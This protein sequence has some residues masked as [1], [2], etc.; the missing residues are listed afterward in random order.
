MSGRIPV[1]W[2]LNGNVN[3]QEFTLSGEGSA[4]LITGTTELRLEAAPTLPNGFEPALSH[5][6]CNFALAGYT[7]VPHVA[8]SLRDVVASELF[9]RPRRQVEITDM[10]G[11]QIV[12]LEA[13]TTMT[14]SD[15]VISVTNYMTGFSHLPAPVLNASGAETLVPGTPGTATGTAQ[16]QVEL[17]NGETLEGMTVVPYRF[18]RK[19]LRVTPAIRVVRDQKCWWLSETVVM[20]R[21]TS[22]WQALSLYAE[23]LGV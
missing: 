11:E 7:A 23:K 9:V 2:H 6:I 13:L 22:E 17:K 21:A 8:V 12:R 16:Y 3:S 10:S 20:L 14:V 4:D 15:E 18:D 5:L 1:T 19:D